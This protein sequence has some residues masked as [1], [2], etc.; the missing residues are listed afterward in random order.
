MIGLRFLSCVKLLTVAL[1]ATGFSLSRVSAEEGFCDGE[2]RKDERTQ[3]D[4][5]RLAVNQFNVS[6]NLA[7][8]ETHFAMRWAKGLTKTIRQLPAGSKIVDMGA[9]R[10]KALVDALLLNPGI[11]EGV[12]VAF[13]KPDGAAPD[14]A[15]EGRFRYLHGD[16]VENM[17]RD[18]KLDSLIGQ[19]DVITD[20]FGPL[21]YSRDLP[22]LLHI[23][24][25]LLKKDG[26]LFFT[27]MTERGPPAVTVN[28]SAFVVWIR[29]I[30]GIEVVEIVKRKVSGSPISWEKSISVKIRKIADQVDVPRSLATESYEDGSP[31][32]RVLRHS[33]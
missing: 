6:R 19:T 9:G 11:T 31:P 14:V 24:L 18:G 4:S 26:L 33:N 10:G 21:S 22:D 15:V 30:P 1:L 29:S 3:I 23:Y 25:K 32:R 8:Y 12:A 27:L 5:G 17:A 20:L 13:A 2:F 16:Y 7:A 28:P